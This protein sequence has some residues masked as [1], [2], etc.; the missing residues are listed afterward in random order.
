MLFLLT[1]LVIATAVVSIAV[2]LKNRKTLSPNNQ[3]QLENPVYR[4]LFEPDEAEIR[5]FKLE[6]K[7]KIEAELRQKKQKHLAE[8]AEKV[9]VFLK[10]WQNTPNRQ[11]TS[12][13]LYIASQSESGEIYAK[14]AAEVLKFWKEGKLVCFSA[15]NLA[16]ILESH[17]WLISSEQR[18]S[19]VKFGLYQELADLRRKSSKTK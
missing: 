5:A 17:F 2:W 19:G 6:E 3:K 8:K 14:T 4:S 11:N 18:T 9:N 10:T 12:E 7:A 1:I 15:D 16:E 13:L